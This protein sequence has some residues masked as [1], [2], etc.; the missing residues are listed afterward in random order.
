MDYIK[1]LVCGISEYISS[2]IKNIVSYVKPNNV[3]DEPQNNLIEDSQNNVIE[4]TQ[5]DNVEISNLSLLFEEV[6][7]I[8]V[9]IAK[10][11]N[12]KQIIKYLKDE[13]DYENKLSE[14][15]YDDPPTPQQKVDQIV[16]LTIYR[17]LIK[18]LST[19]L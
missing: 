15:C 18:Q 7:K 2:K 3:I 16:K 17:D 9:K 10:T 12:I 19:F 6:A 5:N 13:I 4:E 8:N 14:F 1:E 11:K